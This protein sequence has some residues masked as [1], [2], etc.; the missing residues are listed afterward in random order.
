MY[1]RCETDTELCCHFCNKII[2]IDDGKLYTNYQLVQLQSGKE[3]HVKCNDCILHFP[4]SFND[5][6]NME[7]IGKIKVY[8][9]EPYRVIN[10]R[11]VKKSLYM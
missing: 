11:Y 4:R 8:V 10:I 6:L 2:S 1:Q 9:R 7:L 3:Y 5:I